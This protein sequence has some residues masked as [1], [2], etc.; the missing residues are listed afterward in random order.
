MLFS[1]ST[2]ELLQYQA[3]ADPCAEKTRWGLSPITYLDTL[4]AQREAGPVPV[5]GLTALRAEQTDDPAAD[6]ARDWLARYDF[7]V[8]VRGIRQ[9]DGVDHTADQVRAALNGARPTSAVRQLTSELALK[10]ADLSA[11]DAGK[12]Q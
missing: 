11:G 7:A 5:R 4:D 8:C 3:E 9:I 1:P 2:A 10:I 6:Q 12:K